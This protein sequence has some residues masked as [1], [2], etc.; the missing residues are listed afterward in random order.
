MFNLTFFFLDTCTT[1]SKELCVKTSEGMIVDY[2]FHFLQ[3]S[4]QSQ[5]SI[6]AREPVIRVLTNL[7]KYHETSWHIWMVSTYIHTIHFQ[8]NNIF[9]ILCSLILMLDFNIIYF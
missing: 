9:M 5:P 3:Y 2:M 6:E 7:L 1:L 8:C 4:N